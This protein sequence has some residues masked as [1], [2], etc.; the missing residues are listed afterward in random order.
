LAFADLAR[1][2]Q[3]WL[4]TRIVDAGVA[5]SEAAPPAQHHPPKLQRQWE[6]RRQETIRAVRRALDSGALERDCPVTDTG[7]ELARLVHRL[8][9]TAAVFG[10]AELGDQA[11][12]LERAIRQNMSI[13]L[14]KALARDLLDLADDRAPSMALAGG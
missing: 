2:L 3:R 6:D 8:A 7:E 14:R 10:E 4:P 9:G 11:A 13:H 5:V 12:A 1:V